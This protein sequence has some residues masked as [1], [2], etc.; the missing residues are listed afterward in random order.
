MMFAAGAAMDLI[1]GQKEAK[2]RLT[3]AAEFTHQND[4]EKKINIG[5]EYELLNMIALRTGYRFNYDE[6]GFTLG[7]GLK[8]TKGNKGIRIDY[9]IM[10]AGRFDTLNMFTISSSL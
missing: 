1:G 10:D 4:G 5:A 9:A 7:G 2:H 3:A 6:F 8:W